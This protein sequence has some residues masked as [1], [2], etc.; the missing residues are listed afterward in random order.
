VIN[1]F[2]DP[3]EQN[4]KEDFERM[5]SFQLDADEE[6]VPM[7][8]NRKKIFKYAKEHNKEGWSAPCLSWLLTHGILKTA[9]REKKSFRIIR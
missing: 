3:K 9:D 5:L 1:I 8:T 7:L 6:S 2:G 4:A